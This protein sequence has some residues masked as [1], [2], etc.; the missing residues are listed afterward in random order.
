MIE[1]YGDAET[2]GISTVRELEGSDG[3]TDQQQSCSD[4]A[5]RKSKWISIRLSSAISTR[6]S[7]THCS[8]DFLIDRDPTLAGAD[9][10]AGVPEA[11]VVIAASA[12]Q[13]YVEAGGGLED[14][15]SK[16]LVVAG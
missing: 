10:C 7:V 8:M 15:E 11:E 1:K 6:V 16:V 12:V 9:V 14:V 2:D 5:R 3:R 4:S 13:G